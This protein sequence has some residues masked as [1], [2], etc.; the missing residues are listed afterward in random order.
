MGGSGSRG[1]LYRGAV[2]I[3]SILFAAGEGKR[4]RPLTDEVAKPAV[5]VLDVPLGAWGL[6]ALVRNAPPVIVN[7]SH[8]ALG[9]EAALR[10]V[11]PNGWELFYEGDEGF[12]TGGTVAALAGRLSGPVVLFNGDLISDLDVGEVLATHRERE[13]GIT[14][15][16]SAVAAGADVRLEGTDISGFV[17]RRVTGSAAGGRYLGVAVIEAE[18]ARRIPKT[19][20]L[21][22]GESVFG[23]LAERGWLAAHVHD[24]YALDVG[25]IDRYLEAS[26]DCLYGR[27]P[28]PPRA[29]PGDL[30]EVDGGRAYIGPGAKAADGALGPG[31]V[32]LEGCEVAAGAFVERAVIWR[33]E[34]VTPGHEVR[35]AV[36]IDDGAIY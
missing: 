13:A 9:L 2:A 34:V 18:V 14:L 30:V 31:A 16:V 22:L 24:G 19:V 1:G 27:A 20:P 35:D 25:T 4:L 10:G 12:G 29:W 33:K 17:D 23:P 32:L 28:A 5:P 11:C 7:A 6:S 36:W 26:F 15:A 21:G 3:G 8:Q